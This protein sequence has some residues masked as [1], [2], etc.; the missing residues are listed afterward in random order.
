MKNETLEQ[1]AQS[2]NTSIEIV[3]EIEKIANHKRTVQTIWDRPTSAEYDHVV[4]NAFTSHDVE[5]FTWGCVTI[6]RPGVL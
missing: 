3:Q 6:P 2:V 4:L 5:S 1:W